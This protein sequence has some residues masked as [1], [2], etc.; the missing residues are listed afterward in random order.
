MCSE[1][2]WCFSAAWHKGVHEQ[3]QWY[4]AYRCTREPTKGIG[5]PESF[6][7]PYITCKCLDKA[8]TIVNWV[9]VGAH[10]CCPLF[11]QHGD[12]DDAEPC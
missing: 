10:V 7:G 12:V 5:F 2:G 6:L 3:G 11:L 4:Q 8:S 9:L 1:V